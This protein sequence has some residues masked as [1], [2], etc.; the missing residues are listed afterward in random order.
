MT[1][2]TETKIRRR[3]RGRGGGEDV[4]RIKRINPRTGKNRERG[5]ERGK[6]VF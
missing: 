1:L 2:A 6:S 3:G 5:K 4:G